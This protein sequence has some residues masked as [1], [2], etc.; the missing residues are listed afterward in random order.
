MSNRVDLFG[1]FAPPL[2]LRRFTVQQYR[3]LGELGVL[4][5]TTMLNYL[6]AGS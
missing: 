5:R 2:H 1:E 4:T 3:Q 6:K